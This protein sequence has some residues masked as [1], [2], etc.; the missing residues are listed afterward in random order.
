MEL[1]ACLD[2]AQE[3]L[4]GC[5]EYA[6]SDG[7]VQHFERMILNVV[8]FLHESGVLDWD[9]EIDYDALEQVLDA[10]RKGGEE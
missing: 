4:D 7:E 1:A 2:V 10:M 6:V 3:H 9:Q 5:A 8:D